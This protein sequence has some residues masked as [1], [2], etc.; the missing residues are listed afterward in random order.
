[1]PVSPAAP[2]AAPAEPKSEGVPVSVTG[3]PIDS[4]PT[5]PA[6][7][8]DLRVKRLIVTHA[9]EDR[10]PAPVTT[11]VAGQGKV[12]AFV[13]LSSRSDADGRIIVSFE[14][15]AGTKVGLVELKV[16]ANSP[17]W[18]TWAQTKLIKQPGHWEAVVRTPDGTE[19]SRTGFEVEPPNAS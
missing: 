2:V 7:A 4:A 16:P 9:V 5:E 8:D 12:L 15:Q 17:R 11:L 3:K 1:V 10:E 19:L 18:R 13:E 6:S 14:H